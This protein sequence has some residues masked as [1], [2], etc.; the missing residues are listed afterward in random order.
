MY[1]LPHYQLSN[2]P[3]QYYLLIFRC[4]NQQVDIISSSNVYFH[5]INII[6]GIKISRL[7]KLLLMKGG[8]GIYGEVLG[9]CTHK[10]L[11]S[12]IQRECLQFINNYKCQKHL[13]F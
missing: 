6:Y 5:I 13:L 7:P 11:C 12:L 8:G 1:L 4:S 10:L 2:E 9:M 3:I